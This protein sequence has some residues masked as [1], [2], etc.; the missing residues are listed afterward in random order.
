MVGVERNAP[1]GLVLPRGADDHRTRMNAMAIIASPLRFDTPS[2]ESVE[3]SR[4]PVSTSDYT[5]YS[6]QINETRQVHVVCRNVEAYPGV[7]VLFV[8]TSRLDTLTPRPSSTLR[9]IECTCQK[10]P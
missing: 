8:P 9:Q 10:P 6:Y 7:G 2:V 5:K 3:K 1:A 4:N